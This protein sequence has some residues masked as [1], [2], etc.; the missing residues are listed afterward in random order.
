MARAENSVLAGAEF[1]AR[2]G[3]G[4][5]LHCDRAEEAI[6]LRHHGGQLSTRMVLFIAA[7]SRFLARHRV[8]NLQGGPEA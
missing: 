7:S 4:L 3:R 8:W 2:D 5:Q 1:S 6:F